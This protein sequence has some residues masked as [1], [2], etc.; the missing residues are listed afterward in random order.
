VDIGYDNDSDAV[1]SGKKI[2][3]RRS[4][5]RIDADLVL[6]MDVLEHVDDDIGFLN[7]YVEKMPQGAR[8]LISVP[9]FQ[10]LWSAHDVFLEHKR[11]YQLHQIEDVAC[12]AGLVIVKGIYYFGAVFPIAAAIRLFSWK[13]TNG[14]APIH[15]QL[16][17]HHS[18]VNSTLAG[19]C[20]LELPLMRFNR[21]VGLSAFCLAEKT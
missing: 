16:S 2:H 19:L 3:F 5:E 7:G 6:F 4:I 15:S 1:E 13:L 10:F 18:L 11:R 8:F 12:H 17:R 9:A 21:A 20:R 14:K